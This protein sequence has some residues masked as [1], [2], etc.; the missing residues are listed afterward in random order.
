MIRF[1]TPLALLAMLSLS[2]VTSAAILSDSFDADSSASY[3]VLLSNPAGDDVSFAFDYGALG[4]PEAP[5]SVGAT[6]T[7]VRMRANN[8]APTA[9]SSAVQIAPV[10]LAP[11]LV[12]IDY[13]LTYDLWVNYNG[14]APG[15]GGGSTEAMMVGVGFDDSAAIAV[16][17]SNG[18]YFTITGDGGSSTDVRSFTN[19][20]FN[21]A[22]INQGPSNNSA[23]AYYAGIF[24]G[25]VDVGALPVQGGTDN[26]TGTTV[27]GQMA[28]SWH[29][30]RVDVT[31]SKVDFYV[32]NLLIASDAD[33]DISGNIFLGYADYF[34]SNSD[35]PQW[36]F[37]IVDNL[38]VT[39]LVPEPTSLA[40]VGFAATML[41]FRRR[42]G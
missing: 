22:G 20:G 40:L 8:D 39:A 14:T 41:G 38:A 9:S 37:G 42:N 29:E 33:A 2:V 19:D 31:G 26:Q 7:G 35:A 36:S 23:D 6:S 12:G 5:N 10:G 17:N 16:G 11:S 21:G 4:I 25:G 30:V 1:M 18:T 15:G 3:N 13:S 34:S 27:Q 24:P 32:D 28:F